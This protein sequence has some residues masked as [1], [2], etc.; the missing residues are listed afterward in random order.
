MTK[1]TS[2]TSVPPT[3]SAEPELGT[4]GTPLTGTRRGLTSLLEEL[5]LRPVAP[6]RRAPTNLW[7]RLKH[8]FGIHSP[9][10]TL[11]TYVND[12]GAVS[13]YRIVSECWVCD[14]EIL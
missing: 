6:W 1:D 9:L 11:R 2:L 4:N 3:M 13:S 5:K 7:T 12:W 8:L 10:P 14:K